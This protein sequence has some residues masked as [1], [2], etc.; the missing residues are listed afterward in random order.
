MLPVKMPS[1]SSFADLAR[2]SLFFGIYGN[3]EL[4]SWMRR[5][6]E[7][8]EDQDQ[9]MIKVNSIDDGL[10][11]GDVAPCPLLVGAVCLFGF[12]ATVVTRSLP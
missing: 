3:L 11:V 5:F 12:S 8:E 2:W 9:K 10:L 7:V 4:F 6:L 1:P